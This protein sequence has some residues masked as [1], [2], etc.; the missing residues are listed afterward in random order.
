MNG[1]PR[2]IVVV[3]GVAAGAS[4]ATKA[5]RTDEGA[6]IL[7]FERGPYVSFANCGLPYFVG[8]DIPEVED[9][10]LMTPERFAE[11]FR[12][13]VELHH[14]ATRIDRSTRRIQVRDLRSGEIRWEPYDRL[15]L[16]PGSRPVM[17][18]IPGIDRPG[19]FSLTTVPDAEELRR[20]ARDPRVRQA[21]V[22]G[23]G[24][25]GL[26]AGAA[27]SICFGRAAGATVKSGKQP[28]PPSIRRRA[29]PGGAD[30]RAT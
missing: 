12:I 5:R 28:S 6:E 11:R 20:W 30:S 7:T 14:E 16:A 4:A 22:V 27:R 3:G 1:H 26:E 15:I 2:R 18:P 25:I 9:L 29:W 21:V 13:R 24:F 10:L 23:A 19:V 8:G 17:T